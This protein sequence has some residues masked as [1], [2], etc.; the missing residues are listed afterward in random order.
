M[1]NIAV[2]DDDNE[3]SDKLYNLI[4]KF[5]KENDAEFA[6]ECFSNGDALLQ[7]DF[8]KFDIIFLDIAMEGKDG[9]QTAKDLRAGGYDMEL[10][11]CTNLE[12]YAIEGYSVDAL[13]YLIKPVTEYS[14]NSHLKKA[15]ARLRPKTTGKVYIKTVDGD[16]LTS[17]DKIIYIEVQKHNLFYHV[18]SGENI[19][20]I[21]SRGSM[22]GV[23]KSINSPLF[24]Q[25]SASFY[26]NTCYVDSVRKNI[27]YIAN[28]TLPLSR[29]FKKEFIDKLM[30]YVLLKGAGKTK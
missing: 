22:R 4:C 16:M 11:F 24:A 17:I 7:S 25:S 9:L 30:D 14:L 10:F 5:G 8:K 21:R 27:I 6:V 28:E 2:V 23:M 19:E 12:Q 26:V 3:A 1:Y 20:I 15:C 18:K 13:G 29:N